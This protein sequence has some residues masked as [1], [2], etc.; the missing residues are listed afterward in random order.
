MEQEYLEL[1]FTFKGGVDKKYRIKA[2]PGVPVD[3]AGL[4]G[5]IAG[6]VSMLHDKEDYPV[7]TD[8]EGRVFSIPNLSEIITIEARKVK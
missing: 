1:K 3:D 7:M 5:V 2:D 8:A 6:I 4:R